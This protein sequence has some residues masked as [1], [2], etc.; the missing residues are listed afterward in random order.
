MVP[1]VKPMLALK[2][3]SLQTDM[4][5]YPATLEVANGH[6]DNST[7]VVGY[8]YRHY[9]DRSVATEILQAYGLKAM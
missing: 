9:C 3:T 5:G 2:S 6:N 4:V 8:L 1:V 7:A